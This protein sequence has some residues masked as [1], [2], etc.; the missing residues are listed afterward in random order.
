VTP[1][2]PREVEVLAAYAEL[3]DWQAV[4]T[5]LGIGCQ[6]TKSHANAAYG[7]L[8]VDGAIGAL[9]AMRWLTPPTDGEL[10][11]VI[12]EQA[13]ADALLRL[14]AIEAEIAGLV[15]QLTAPGSDAPASDRAG[16][17]RTS[18]IAATP[19]PSLRRVV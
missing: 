1:L 12:A 13:R 15:D 16:S 17:S 14:Q 3:G 10:A 7:K 4:A 8:G 5:R 6:T 11:V 18:D 9:R 19:A 2:T